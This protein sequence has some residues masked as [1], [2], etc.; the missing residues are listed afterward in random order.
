MKEDTYNPIIDFSRYDFTP[1]CRKCDHSYFVYGVELNCERL[2]ENKRCRFK[3]KK[4][5]NKQT[6]HI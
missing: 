4:D 5:E 2:N 6:K 1:N 3:E